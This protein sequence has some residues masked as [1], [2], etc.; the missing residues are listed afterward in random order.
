MAFHDLGVLMGAQGWGLSARRSVIELLLGRRAELNPCTTLGFT[1][2][3]AAVHGGS[4]ALRIIWL[5]NLPRTARFLPL[6]RDDLLGDDAIDGGVACCRLLLQYGID[7][8]AT[9]TPTSVQGRLLCAMLRATEAFT[10]VGSP[11][12]SLS[13]APGTTA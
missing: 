3:L 5:A 13:S 10:H 1:A 8:N 4:K 11:R 9:A 6:S 7:V 12:R 2:L